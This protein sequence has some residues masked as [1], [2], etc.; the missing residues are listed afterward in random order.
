MTTIR[1]AL[2]AILR[3]VGLSKLADKLQS[4]V[5]GGGGGPMEPP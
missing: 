2:A 5:I 4:R 3:A 1:N